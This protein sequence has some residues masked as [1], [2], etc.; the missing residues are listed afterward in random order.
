MAH[1]GYEGASR[2]GYEQIEEWR[3]EH[4]FTG[5][6]V[7]HHLYAGNIIDQTWFNCRTPVLVR[8]EAR[9]CDPFYH[10]QNPPKLMARGGYQ[11]TFK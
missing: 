7:T 2:F 8:V 1:E 6:R 9:D 10:Y 11:I 5:L 4:G 3:K